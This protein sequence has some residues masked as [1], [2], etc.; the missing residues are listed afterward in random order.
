M[1]EKRPL[2]GT[3]VF[4]VKNGKFLLGKRKSHFWDG[5]W[6]IPWWHLEF[7]ETLEE[8]WKRETL[9]EAWIQIQDIEFLGI[10]NDILENKHYVT[11]FM[12][13][14][15]ESW[16][17]VVTDFDEFYEWKW[18]DLEELPENLFDIFRNFLE[19]NKGVIVEL[20]GK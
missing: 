7:W 5:K 6:C 1:K 4:V 10:S 3:G 20:L 19:K 15:Y 13:S 8:C 17:A 12:K 18:V 14:T 9:E 11:V 2:V 16:E